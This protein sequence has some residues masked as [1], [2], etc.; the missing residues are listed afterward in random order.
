[1]VTPDEL[2][3]VAARY[4]AASGAQV[5]QVNHRPSLSIGDRTVGP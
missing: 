3:E 5:G 4:A 1:V 2:A